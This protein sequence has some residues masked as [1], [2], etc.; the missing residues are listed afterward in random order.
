MASETQRK[1]QR[2]SAA[3]SQALLVISFMSVT[4]ILADIFLKMVIYNQLAHTRNLK[5]IILLQ[6]YCLTAIN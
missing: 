2:R 5:M 1:C 4:L 6:I 3:D